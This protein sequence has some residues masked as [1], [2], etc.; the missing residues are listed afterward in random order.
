MKK[1]SEYSNRLEIFKKSLPELS[2]YEIEKLVEHSMCTNL[3]NTYDEIVTWAEKIKKQFDT[4][5]KEI[6]LKNLRNWNVGSNKIA[7][8]SGKFFE[9]LGFRVGSNSIRE[10]EAGWDQPII[11]E[12][13]FDGGVLCLLRT[14]I[15]ELPHYLIQARFEP[16]NYNHIQLS[17]S[18]I[19]I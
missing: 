6:P 10:V 16:G 11:K 2:T 15:E 13:G 5:I 1:K 17:L 12:H 8:S 4:E 19:H 14:Y 18:L 7:H 9:V 3:L